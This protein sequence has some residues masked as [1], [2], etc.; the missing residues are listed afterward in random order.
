MGDCVAE[1]LRGAAVKAISVLGSTGSIGTQTLELAE[2]FPD[3]FRVVALLLQLAKRQPHRTA[4]PTGPAACGCAGRTGGCAGSQAR[5]RHH[6]RE[7]RDCDRTQRG[8]AQ[9]PDRA[10]PC[11]QSQQGF[12]TA[13]QNSAQLLECGN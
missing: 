3:R 10:A 1:T 6:P 11:H 2:E 8:Q 7:R 9:R 12:A 4:N 5:T 13:D